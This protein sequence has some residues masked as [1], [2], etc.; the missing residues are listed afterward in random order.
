MIGSD[1]E[2]GAERMTWGIPEL[3][4]GIG[5][6]V[7]GMGTA[8]LVGDAL[9]ADERRRVASEMLI[10]RTDRNVAGG[11]NWLDQV[12]SMAADPGEARAYLRTTAMLDMTA[13]P[14]DV[15]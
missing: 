6:V 3:S 12:R 15:H 9:A 13:V 10:P 8:G 7:V 14:T 4:D 11:E 1:L 2:T 5:F